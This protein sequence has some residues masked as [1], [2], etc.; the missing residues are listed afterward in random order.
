MKAWIIE[1]LKEAPQKEMSLLKY[2]ANPSQM[3]LVLPAATEGR[4][5]SE[6]QTAFALIQLVGMFSSV[7]LHRSN[8]PLFA[9]YCRL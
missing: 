7:L 8:R 2:R 6:E 3:P 9:A 1:R 5:G 4:R